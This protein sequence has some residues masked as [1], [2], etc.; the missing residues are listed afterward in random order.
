MLAV[1]DRRSAPEVFVNGPAIGW[2]SDNPLTPLKW[3]PGEWLEY[4]EQISPLNAWR[5]LAVPVRTVTEEEYVR[6]IAHTPTVVF[7]SDKTTK[8]VPDDKAAKLLWESPD[9][10]YSLRG[11]ETEPAPERSAT[12]SSDWR[13]YQKKRVK[14]INGPLGDGNSWIT[15]K[16]KNILVQ[17]TELSPWIP[18]AKAA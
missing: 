6:F 4:R 11:Y 9:K 10:F 3:A 1:A 8:A 18:K 14:F 7:A 13:T 15:L 2:R 17:N 12:P 5:S 16:G